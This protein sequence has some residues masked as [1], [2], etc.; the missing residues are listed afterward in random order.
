MSRPANIPS[1]AKVLACLLGG[2]GDDWHLQAPADC[3][4]DL[5]N[6]H[7]LF[8]DRVIPGS[9]FDAL[10][11]RQPVEASSIEQ[12]HRGP[13]VEPVADIR[14]NTFL[15]SDSDHVGDEALL[16]AVVDLRK[17]HH[18]HVHARAASE[19]AVSSEARGYELE[20]GGAASSSVATR[21]GRQQP[22]P[23]GDDQGAV[24]ARERGAERL[25]GAPVHL[26]V[27]RE[28][29]E[30]VVEGAVNHAVR[31]GCSAAQA[32]QVFEITSVHLRSGGDKRLG[33]RI[34]ACKTKHLMARVD[35]LLNDGR[36]D[37]SCSSCNENTHFFSSYTGRVHVA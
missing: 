33:T 22:G 35:Q 1:Q 5:S 25:D 8:G 9:R 30:V 17:A 32:F 2:L 10:L 12:M 34:G 24:R 29:R 36:T 4:S 15:P 28:L 14:R 21:S 13:A 7:A 3:L 11:K 18:R 37:K 27:R 31:H 20:T 16:D 23:G 19:A 6:R 26:T